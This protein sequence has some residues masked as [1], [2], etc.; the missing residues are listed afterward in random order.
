MVRESDHVLSEVK[1]ICDT[2]K[3]SRVRVLYWDTQVCRDEVYEMD[4]LDKLAQSTS[5]EVVVAQ[6]SS[7]FQSTWQSMASNHKRL[8]YL[9]MVTWVGHGAVGLAPHYG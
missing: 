6:R 4:E 3:P 7:A 8:S 9:Q 2:V 1:A 5:R